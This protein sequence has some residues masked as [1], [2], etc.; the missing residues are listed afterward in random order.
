M[1]QGKEPSHFFILFKGRMVVHMGG[2]ASGF[3]NSKDVS[4]ESAGKTKA[5]YHVRGTSDKNTHA[6]QTVL[7]AASL[8]SGDCFIL[9]VPSL[10]V[11]LWE[12]KFSSPQERK[13][14]HGVM[15][16]LAHVRMPPAPSRPAIQPRP[17]SACAARWRTRLGRSLSEWR[18][19]ELR[20]EV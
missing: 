19:F 9:I 12:G 16:S 17:S 8:N 1:T 13:F 18:D 5:L 7:E 20:G 10:R 3:K 6:C 15:A 14:A 2:K 4:D 11:F